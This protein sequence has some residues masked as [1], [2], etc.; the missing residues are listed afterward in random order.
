MPDGEVILELVKQARAGNETACSELYQTMAGQV[1]RLAYGILLNSQDAEEVVQDSFV[2]A[3]QNLHRYD[4]S[5]S[6][7]RTWLYMITL[8]RCRN[9]RRRKWLP[10]ISLTELADWVSG[11]DSQPE[12]S[13]E[14]TYRSDLVIKAMAHLSPKLREAVAL[15]YFDGLS[16]RE[17]SEI[18]GCPQKTAESRIRLAHEEL[19][20]I[21]SSWDR[22]MVDEAYESGRSR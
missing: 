9:K 20:R 11:N 6:A 1:Y 13:A 7:F 22:S 19:Y 18:I 14:T 15:R 21:I 10:T 5:K 17:M 2:Y 4:S 12:S 16:F 3:L 8:S